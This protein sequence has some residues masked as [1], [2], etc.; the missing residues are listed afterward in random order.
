MEQS[1]QIMYNDIS[2]LPAFTCV[3]CSP[4][5]GKAV[6]DLWRGVIVLVGTFWSCTSRMK[7]LFVN[8]HPCYLQ[9][10]YNEKLTVS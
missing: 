9:F 3:T 6:T 1:S 7:T 8:L 2:T 5:A 10:I 4:N